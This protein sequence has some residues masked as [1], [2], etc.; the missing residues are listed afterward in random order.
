[1]PADDDGYTGP[2]TLL[3]AGH[4][5]RV[6]VHLRG[7]FQ[8]IDGHYRWYGRI[9]RDDALHELAGGRKHEAELRTPAGSARGELSDPDPWGRYRILG[10]STPPFPVPATLAEAGE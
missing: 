3:M 9:A 6:E 5:F 1:M 8:P 2:A 4:E 7:H 10:V